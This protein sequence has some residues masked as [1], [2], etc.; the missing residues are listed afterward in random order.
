MLHSFDKSALKIWT[1]ID[2]MTV[3]TWDFESES[4]PLTFGMCDNHNQSS[5][6]SFFLIHIAVSV[7]KI[8]VHSTASVDKSSHGKS[9]T[10]FGCFHPAWP[11]GGSIYLLFCLKIY[12]M[13]NSSWCCKIEFPRGSTL[14]ERI[15]WDAVERWWRSWWCHRRETVL[16]P[17]ASVALCD[18]GAHHNTFFRWE[19]LR[20]HLP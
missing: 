19:R 9:S 7:L 16:Y 11:R 2:M 8:F 20:N 10:E 6:R 15:P 14:A 5:N 3:M 12:V 1:R 18:R 4:R 13:S 17:I